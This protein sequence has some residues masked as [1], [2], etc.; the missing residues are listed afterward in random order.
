MSLPSSRG[1][2]RLLAIA[3]GLVFGL[4]VAEAFLQLADVQPERYRSPRWSAFDG[5]VFRPSDMWADGLIKQQ[6]PLVEI[7]MG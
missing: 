2:K 5:S 7:D 4:V 3:A 1:R 6:G